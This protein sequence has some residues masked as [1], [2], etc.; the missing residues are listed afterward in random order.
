MYYLSTSKSVQNLLFMEIYWIFLCSVPVTYK[1]EWI[2]VRL[3]RKNLKF[4]CISCCIS[5]VAFVYQLLNAFL[6]F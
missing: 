2:L 4:A 6:M 3:V 5:C 1:E